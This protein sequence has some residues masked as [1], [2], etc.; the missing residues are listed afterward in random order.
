MAI[1]GEFF[2]RQK[3]R[4][5]ESVRK[6]CEREETKNWERPR[7]RGLQRAFYYFGH[8]GFCCVQLSISPNFLGVLLGVVVFSSFGPEN[9]L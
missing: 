6:S 2:L 8:D 1:R 5:Q 9:A 4:L 3:S 7:G